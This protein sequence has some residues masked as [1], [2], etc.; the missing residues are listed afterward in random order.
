MLISAW[1]AVHAQSPAEQVWARIAARMR[2]SLSL[3]NGQHDSIY[4]AN[5]LLH[6]MKDSVRK[7]FGS[8]LWQQKIQLIENKRDSLYRIVLTPQQ[9][10]LYRVRKRNIISAN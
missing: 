8:E 9:Y 10:E 7:N 2:D 5:M 3:T 1:H 4:S 6:A